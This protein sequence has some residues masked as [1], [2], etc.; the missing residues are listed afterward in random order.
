MTTKRL[1]LSLQLAF[2]LCVCAFMVVPVIMSALAGLTVNYFTGLQSGLTLRWIIEVWNGYGDTIFRSIGIALA[3]LGLTLVFGVPVAYVLARRQTRLTRVIEEML[4][5]PVAVPGLATALALISVFGSVGEFRT[6]WTFI[7][8]GHVLFTLPFMV[9]A[10]LSVLLALD[11]RTLEDGAASLGANALQRFFHIIIPNCRD[12]ILAGSLMVL[13]LSIGEFNLTWLLH[14][15][16]TKTLPVGLADAYASMRLE[17]G[18]AYT[19][20][21]FLMIVPLLL[22]MQALARPRKRSF[23]PD[24]DDTLNS[25]PL[26]P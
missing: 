24:N 25:L 4:M 18:S 14:T 12:G 5:L 6:S 20:I 19:L 2:T 15:P 13:T 21:F 3:C 11:L 8:V 22:A 9:R 17:V 16:H 23:V 7:L 10:V 1:T 26:K